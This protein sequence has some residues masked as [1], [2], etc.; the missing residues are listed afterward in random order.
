HWR[1]GQT[2]R[3]QW[4]FRRVESP[5]PSFCRDHTRQRSIQRDL[6]AYRGPQSRSGTR[7]CN[8]WDVVER[9]DP[10]GRSF[11]GNAHRTRKYDCLVP[12][13][14][15][16]IQARCTGVFLSRR[17]APRLASAS[18]SSL[19]SPPLHWDRQNGRCRIRPTSIARQAIRDRHVEG[20]DL[21]LFPPQVLPEEQ[22]SCPHG[23]RAYL[24]AVPKVDHSGVPET[25]PL[26]HPLLFRPHLCSKRGCRTGVTMKR[27]QQHT[28]KLWS[29]PNPRSFFVLCPFRV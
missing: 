27:K 20:V 28:T 5:H 6:R 29:C 21:E 22:R 9:G 23:V 19:E 17:K 24:L 14:H 26:Q 13:R 15:A 2:L 7:H 12:C 8:R 18:R 10:F 16:P 1:I 11:R 3:P 25:L 4:S